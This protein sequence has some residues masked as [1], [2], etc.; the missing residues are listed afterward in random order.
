MGEGILAAGAGALLGLTSVALGWWWRRRRAP[1]T[2]RHTAHHGRAGVV[3]L[4]CRAEERIADH[5]Q[6]VTGGTGQNG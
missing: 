3:C 1:R 2:C 6:R 4:A 5:L